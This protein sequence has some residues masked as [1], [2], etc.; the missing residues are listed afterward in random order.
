MGQPRKEMTMV[1]DGNIWQA[2]GFCLSSSHFS[3]QVSWKMIQWFIVIGGTNKN[4]SLLIPEW[5]EPQS[6]LNTNREAE[7]LHCGNE[8]GSSM[9]AAKPDLCFE[10]SLIP[11]TQISHWGLMTAIQSIILLRWKA[12]P[13]G[14]LD[15]TWFNQT[16][17][18]AAWW[19]LLRQSVATLFEQKTRLRFNQGV[20]GNCALWL[21]II[22]RMFTIDQSYCCLQL[23]L[24]SSG[25]LMY[26]LVIFPECQHSFESP[27]ASLM[28]KYQHI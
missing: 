18:M 7:L 9:G 3:F 23:T 16:A 25:H 28:D 10:S 14:K 6:I 19:L 17:K 21:A 2:C 4:K 15:L 1:K 11:S 13:I 26:C 27:Q 22:L 20:Q 5:A 12:N 8:A 24:P